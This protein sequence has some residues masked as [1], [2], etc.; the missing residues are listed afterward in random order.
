[1]SRTEERLLV[2]GS[3]WSNLQRWMDRR[4]EQLLLKESPQSKL[5]RWMDRREKLLSLVCQM[6][7]KGANCILRH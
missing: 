6:V 4:E 7:E 5:R 2:K 3:P 1:M